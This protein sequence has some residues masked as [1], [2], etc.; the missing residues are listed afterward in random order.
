MK[1]N[2][3]SETS[4]QRTKDAQWP[5]ARQVRADPD[6]PFQKPK[7]GC[8]G[9]KGDFDHHAKLSVFLLKRIDSQEEEEVEEEKEEEEVE[10]E[11]LVFLR[12]GFS[13]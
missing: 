13:V 4:K 7:N 2:T 9:R 5:Q 11:A 3:Q 8:W 1:R 6:S 12:Q 10:E